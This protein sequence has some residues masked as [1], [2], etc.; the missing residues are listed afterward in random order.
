M[1]RKS[2]KAEKD[3]D[4]LPDALRRKAEAIIDRLEAEP[5]LGHKLKGKLEGLRSVR[6]GRT[7]RIIYETAPVLKVLTVVPRKDAYR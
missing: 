3:L 1:T 4:E 6:L 2:K 5:A 7:H